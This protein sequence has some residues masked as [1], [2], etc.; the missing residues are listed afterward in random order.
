MNLGGNLSLGPS[1]QQEEDYKGNQGG[2]SAV[3]MELAPAVEKF[4]GHRRIFIQPGVGQLLAQRHH[5]DKVVRKKQAHEDAIQEPPGVGAR[6]PGRG[7][8]HKVSQKPASRCHGTARS[9]L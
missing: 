4:R 6:E 2:K 7:A 5:Q 1:E 8:P 3:F 9:K